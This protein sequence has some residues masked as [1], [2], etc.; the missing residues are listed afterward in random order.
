MK[1]GYGLETPLPIDV[2]SFT[3]FDR[4]LLKTNLSRVYG[5]ALV[6]LCNQIKSEIL[7]LARYK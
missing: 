1:L 5:K 4:P 7:L 3:L 2:T 6:H